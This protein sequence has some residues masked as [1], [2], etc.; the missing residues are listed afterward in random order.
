MSARKWPGNVREL[1][2]AVE[3][4]VAFGEE[5][6]GGEAERPVPAA[7]DNDLTLDDL[8]PFKEEKAQIISAFE[9]RYLRALLPRHGNN[10]SASAVA[11]G[12]DRVHLL[13]LLDKYNLRAR[14]AD[15]ERQRS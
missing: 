4:L 6:L 2:N 9:E 1:R 14:G 7:A 12:L 15:R 11:A 8:G 13:R 10:I 5:P 3:A